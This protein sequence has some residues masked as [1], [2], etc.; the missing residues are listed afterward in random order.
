MSYTRSLSL[1]PRAVFNVLSYGATGDGTTNDTVA[2]QAAI[3]DAGR[4]SVVYFPPP[5]VSYRV[6]SLLVNALSGVKLLG[7]GPQA[8]ILNF[9]AT[10][11][12]T[13]VGSGADPGVCVQFANAAGQSIQTQCSMEGISISSNADS[14][15]KVGIR[16]VESGQFSLKNCTVSGMYGGP[17]GSVG[18]QVMGHEFLTVDTLHLTGSVPLRISK[19]PKAYGSKYYNDGYGFRNMYL[20]G[21]SAAG[22]PFEA[23]DTVNLPSCCVKI[24][25]DVMPTN[26]L[27]D[28]VQA[29]VGGKYGLYCVAPTTNFDVQYGWAFHNVRKEGSYG[30][31]NKMFYLDYTSNTKPPENIL[32]ENCLTGEANNT[33]F[34]LR[35]CD[36]TT[37]LNCGRVYLLTGGYY[38][39]DVATTKAMHWTN[40]RS[41]VADNNNLANFSG[42]SP[43]NIA[44]RTGW[45]LPNSAVWLA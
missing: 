19:P 34:Y 25:D 9:H 20:T 10:G 14:F 35:N 42:G 27:F 2:I 6:N 44:L 13:T 7:G 40:M 28:G 33:M 37:M 1:V 23:A 18:M 39:A 31:L 15:D 24:D 11:N 29:W 26:L 38:I 16:L 3:D 12:A 41:F 32:F 5:D 36:T 45:A 8:T 22:A 43:F 17:V 30:T 21:P 4:N